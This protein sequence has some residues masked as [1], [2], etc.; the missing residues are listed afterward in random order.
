MEETVISELLCIPGKSNHYAVEFSYLEE[1]CQSLDIT[2]IPCL[3]ENFIGMANYKGAI[4]PVIQLDETAEK[5]HHGMIMILKY[6]RYMVGVWISDGAF[7]ATGDV[8]RKI[9][10]PE[11]TEQVAIWKYKEIYQVEE[12]LYFL[13]DVKKTLENLVLYP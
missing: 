6:D 11:G 8:M 3:P 7:I 5:K 1:I 10:C 13:I 12:Q 9:E 4:I 2:P